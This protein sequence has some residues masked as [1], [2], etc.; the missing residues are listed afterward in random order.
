MI[1]DKWFNCRWVVT[2]GHR[3]QHDLFCLCKSCTYKKTLQHAPPRERGELH[4]VKE[5]YVKG[6]LEGGFDIWYSYYEPKL[7]SCCTDLVN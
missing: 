1:D 4:F 2:D 3:V 6:R 7:P 5:E